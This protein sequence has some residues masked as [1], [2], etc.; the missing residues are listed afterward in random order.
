MKRYKCSTIILYSDDDLT[1]DEIEE[2]L[3]SRSDACDIIESIILGGEDA[4]NLTRRK[5]E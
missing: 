5:D 4:A 1:P 2:R 3:I